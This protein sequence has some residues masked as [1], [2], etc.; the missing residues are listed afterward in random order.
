MKIPFEDKLIF[1]Q[2]RDKNM[3]L[4]PLFYKNFIDHSDNS[5]KTENNKFIEKLIKTYNNEPRYPVPWLSE[6]SNTGFFPVADTRPP[7]VRP[8]AIALVPT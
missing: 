7:I 5:D 1:D 8:A 2:I 3:L 4:L 6:F